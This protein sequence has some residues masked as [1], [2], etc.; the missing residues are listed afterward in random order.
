MNLSDH[1]KSIHQQMSELRENLS[2]I[3]VE[4]GLTD[5]LKKLGITG[6]L[7]DLVIQ[8][9]TMLI[10]LLVGLLVFV[11]VISCVIKMMKKL[12]VGSGQTGDSDA[13]YEYGHAKHFLIFVKLCCENGQE[14]I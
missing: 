1:S 3:T 5:W 13:G 10:T 11:C 14:D 8:G 12:V 2:A 4:T 9:V 6:W 7:K